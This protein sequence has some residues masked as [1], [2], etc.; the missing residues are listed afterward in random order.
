M[1]PRA[2]AFATSDT[3][4]AAANAIDDNLDNMW[5]CSGVPNFLR[6]DMGGVRPVARLDY[7]G[8]RD[9]FNTRMFNYEVYV[10]SDPIATVSDLQTQG[11][12]VASGTFAFTDSWSGDD[13]PVYAVHFPSA[14]ARYVY[15]LALSA[16]DNIPGA[17]E[18][19]LYEKRTR[20]TV[21]L[22]R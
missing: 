5:S 8:R 14:P 13:V 9:F 16:K 19:W 18:V 20:G 2:S 3:Y 1:L 22:V 11:A 4:G 12:K 6:I 7:L 17:A 10:S 15:L 21:I